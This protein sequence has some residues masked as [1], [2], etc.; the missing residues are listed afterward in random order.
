M[1][2]VAGDTAMH[3]V[4]FVEMTEAQQNAHL[5]GIRSRRLVAVTEY[6]KLQEAKQVARDERIA[7]QADQMMRMM[8]K[9][10]AALDKAL[11]KV[12]ARRA[13]LFGIRALIEQ[14]NE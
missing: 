14:E 8:D 2:V 6:K 10:I 1:T 13:K 9:E 5:D 4:R 11:E 12:E 7:A 3:R